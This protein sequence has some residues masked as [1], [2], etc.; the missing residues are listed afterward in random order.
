VLS[1]SI[2]SSDTGDLELLYMT[3]KSFQTEGPDFIQ[4][5]SEEK[6]FDDILKSGLCKSAKICGCMCYMSGIN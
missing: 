5:L 3:C 6:K 1:W 4:I 2:N